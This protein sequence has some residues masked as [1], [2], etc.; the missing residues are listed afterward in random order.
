MVVRHLIAHAVS[1]PPE[2][3]LAQIAGAHDEGV[4]KVREAK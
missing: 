1:R 2:R 3:E 4:V